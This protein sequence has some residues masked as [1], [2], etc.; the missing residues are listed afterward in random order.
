MEQINEPNRV[1]NDISEWKSRESRLQ[2]LFDAGS[3]ETRE[4]LL[5]KLS[6]M[7][8]IF[9]RYE[10][11]RNKEEQLSL[12]LLETERED[13]L[14]TLYPSRYRRA[15]IKLQRYLRASLDKKTVQQNI[16]R[17]ERV[18]QQDLIGSGF[19]DLNKDV[20]SY[21]KLG[22]PEFSIPYTKSYGA[23]DI[24]AVIFV[25]QDMGGVYRLASFKVELKMVGENPTVRQQVFYPKD[26]IGLENAKDL[27]MGRAVSRDYI[28]LENRVQSEWI[29]LSFLD[30]DGSG[31]H[32]IQKVSDFTDQQIFEELKKLKATELESPS[33]TNGILIRLKDGKSATITSV[34]EGVSRKI[35]ITAN[36]M[37]KTLNQFDD[38]MKPIL[39]ETISEAG[40]L[41]DIGQKVVPAESKKKGLSI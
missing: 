12:K 27:L 26:K 30:K 1:G 37:Q 11:S 24:N 14:K 5:E 16:Y 20:L 2:H 9:A 18:L 15:S 23:E 4:Y 28:N 31:N 19:A 8:G 17:N 29:Q 13:L 39:R 32:P 34:N 33:L 35:A 38:N 6:Y 41:I 21:L 10:N 22:R 36:P 7:D 40:K 25:K 3:F